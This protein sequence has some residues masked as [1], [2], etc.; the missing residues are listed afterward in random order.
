MKYRTIWLL[1]ALLVIIDQAIKIVINSY[2]LNVRFDIIPSLFEFLPTFNYK[3]I[4]LNHLFNLNIGYWRVIIMNIIGFLIILFFYGFFRKRSNNTTLLDTAFIFMNGGMI[5][6]F[7]GT[8]FWGGCLDY[9][10]LKPLFVFDLKDL[11]IDI[12]V[13]LLI[14]SSFKNRKNY[15][16]IKMKDI[17][18]YVKNLFVR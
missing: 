16:S 2:F 13:I 6:A 12:G 14:A 10:Y 17:G 5:S 7:I 18:N 15:D 11:Y 1:I 3:Y 9:I 8:I 4:Y